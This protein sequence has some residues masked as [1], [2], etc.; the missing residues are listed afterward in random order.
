[1]KRSYDIDSILSELRSSWWKSGLPDDAPMISGPILEHPTVLQTFHKLLH[2]EFRGLFIPP[3]PP[4][5]LI[6]HKIAN[7]EFLRLRRADLQV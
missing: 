2:A 7:D 4:K 5:T 1:M 3:L 6:D